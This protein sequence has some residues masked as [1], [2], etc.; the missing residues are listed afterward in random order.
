MNQ[1]ICDCKQHIF[2]QSHEEG[3]FLI[4]GKLFCLKLLTRMKCASRINLYPAVSKAFS[5]N[6][7]ENVKIENLAVGTIF[8]SLT[9][10]D[11][12]LPI[13]LSTDRVNNFDIELNEHH[14][15]YESIVHGLSNAITDVIILVKSNCLENVSDIFITRTLIF[16]RGL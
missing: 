2:K 13:V 12:N 8:R 14:E 9:C 5:V 16:E 3:E 6:H 7:S 4:R 15:S 10:D 11:I 1:T